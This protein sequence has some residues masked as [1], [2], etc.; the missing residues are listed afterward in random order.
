MQWK[1]DKSRVMDERWTET[2]ISSSQEVDSVS[3]RRFQAP[4]RPEWTRALHIRRRERKRI[5]ARVCPPFALH[6][7]G[8]V[9]V[10][11]RR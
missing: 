3:L 5:K 1:P 11:A 8:D 7:A 6:T 4:C 9:P 10:P 2:Q